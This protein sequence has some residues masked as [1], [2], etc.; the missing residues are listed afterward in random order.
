V[1]LPE[2]VRAMTTDQLRPEQKVAGAFGAEFFKRR[3]W[4]FG[5]A[6]EESG[7]FGW[8][9]GLGSSFLIDPAR[10]LIVTVLTQRILESP[11]APQVHQDILAGA[12]V[13]STL[14]RARPLPGGPTRAS[15]G[16]ATRRLRPGMPRTC[17]GRTAPRPDGADRLNP[18]PESSS[19][20][21]GVQR[22]AD[23]TG[24]RRPSR[25]LSGDGRHP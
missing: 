8:D 10:D 9:G 21:G 18:R 17:T 6:V 3:W 14:L 24:S 13:A 5:V 25:A 4:G 7:A 11:V 19:E 1:L 2:H 16:E 12:Y 23:S 15:R 20:S 22:T